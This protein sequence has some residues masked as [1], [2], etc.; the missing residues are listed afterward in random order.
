[1][2]RK[3]CCRKVSISPVSEGFSP[4]GM[5]KRSSL[6]IILNLDEFEAIRLADHLGLYH[7]EAAT[8]MGISRATFG[9]IVADARG[10]VADALVNGKR[11][12]IAGI[13]THKLIE[14][15]DCGETNC[16]CSKEK[17]CC[18]HDSN[19]NLTTL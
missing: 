9:R 8:K 16:L 7:E 14:C 4:L 15:S 3:K 13:D 1:M 18:K 2:P 5:S 17:H 12:Q 10:K 19:T 6:S 11:L